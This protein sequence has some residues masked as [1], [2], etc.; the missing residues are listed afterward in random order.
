MVMSEPR[1]QPRFPALLAG[2]ALLLAGAQAQAEWRIGFESQFFY[3]DDAAL[4]SLT[5]RLLKDQDPSQPVV[6]FDVADQGSDFVYEPALEIEKTF[7]LLGREASLHVLTQGFV[8][9]RKE[10]YNHPSLAVEAGWQLGEQARLYTR[11]FFVSDLF[12]GDNEVRF[13]EGDEEPE[14]FA[15]EVV[16]THVWTLGLR[17]Q[18]HPRVSGTVF[19]RVGIRRYDRPFRQRDTDFYTGGLH[20]DFDLGERAQLIIGFHYERGLADGRNGRQREL[21]DDV[22]YH[23]YFVTNELE[24][25]LLPRLGLEL[26]VHYERNDWTTN[27]AGD[28]RKGEH[29]NQFQ[30]NVSLVYELNETLDLTVGFQGVWRK[31]SFEESL[32]NLN[33][34]LGFRASF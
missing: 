29:E 13:P 8:F 34:W 19:G 12:I 25:E 22:S 10:E 26:A 15:D 3:T 32:R 31:E 20:V 1:R 30:G 5:R 16:T 33:A 11:Y 21:R 14:L 28:E 18:L 9:A 17:H 2:V 4:F 23:N 27:I 24:V 6:D 7:P